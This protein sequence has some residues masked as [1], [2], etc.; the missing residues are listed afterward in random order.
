MTDIATTDDIFFNRTDMDRMR[1]ERIVADA[2]HG[3]DDGELFLEYNQS[4]SFVFDD[5]QLKN[6]QFPAKRPATVTRLSLVKMH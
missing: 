5:G 1:V 2:L 4:E 3:A 6:A